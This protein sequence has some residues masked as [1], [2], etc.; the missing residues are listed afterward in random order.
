MCSYRTG[1]RWGPEVTI[2]AFSKGPPGAMARTSWERR[3]AGTKCG[4]GTW[5]TLGGWSGALGRW[6]WSERAVV[7]GNVGLESGLYP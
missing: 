5:R 6:L 4:G 1:R 3:R 7:T 2:P